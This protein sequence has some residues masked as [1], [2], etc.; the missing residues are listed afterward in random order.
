[1]IHKERIEQKRMLLWATFLS[2]PL[3]F[4][5]IL[6]GWVTA[7]VGRQRVCIA[8]V[9]LLIRIDPRLAHNTT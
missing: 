6:S 4:I 7:E 1:L 9:Q 3:P 2:F 5:A 8:A